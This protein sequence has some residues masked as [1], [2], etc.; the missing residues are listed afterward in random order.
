MK[1]TNDRQRAFRERNKGTDRFRLY[2]IKAHGLSRADYLA[3]LHDQRGGC[4]ICGFKPKNIFGLQVDHDHSCCPGTYGCED[5]VRGLLC[6]TCNAA[7]GMLKEDPRLLVTA[8]QYL[9]HWRP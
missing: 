7:I 4:A 2:H 5:C 3:L 6:L 1:T 8:I 9:T